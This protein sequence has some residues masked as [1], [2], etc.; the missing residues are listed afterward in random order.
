MSNKDITIK[1]LEEQKKE[2]NEKLEHYEFRG[3]S[4]KIQELEDELFEVNDTIK[5][6]N[7]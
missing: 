4:I 1:Q 6:L 3:P 5:K 7:A 2:I